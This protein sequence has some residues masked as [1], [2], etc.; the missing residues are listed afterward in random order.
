MTLTARLKAL[1]QLVPLI[2]AMLL[3]AA[4]IMVAQTQPAHAETISICN[5]SA[6]V[7]SIHAY[8]ISSPWREAN[9]GPGSCASINN[10][11]GAVRVDVDLGGSGGDVDSWYKKR[12]S[13]PYTACVN[14]ED[15]SS[16]PYNNAKTTYRTFDEVYC[17]A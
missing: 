15:G 11:G 13:E 16:D 9:I 3:V 1:P 14:N 2:L 4:G 7:D 5:H 10:D 17:P 6:S 12:N 8:R